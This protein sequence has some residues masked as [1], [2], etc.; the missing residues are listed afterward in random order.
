M[1]H[2]GKSNGFNKIT[3]FRSPFTAHSLPLRVP[4]TE[5]RTSLPL[6][7][8]LRTRLLLVAVSTSVSPPNVGFVDRQASRQN[9]RLPSTRERPADIVP[10]TCQP[11]LQKRAEAWLD[12]HRHS[13]RR[14]P[15]ELTEQRSKDRQARSFKWRAPG[16]AQLVKTHVLDMH[17]AV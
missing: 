16:F 2:F 1:R 3:V 10:S 11:I 4:T 14:T 8:P 7:H 6:R 12:R 15:T 9:A 13:P 5:S 17:I